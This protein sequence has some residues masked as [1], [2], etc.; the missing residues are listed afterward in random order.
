LDG[1][2][3]TIAGNGLQGFA[4]DGSLA[5]NASFNTPADVKVDAQGNVY[6]VDSLNSSIRKLTPLASL[7]TPAITAIGNA[8]SLLGGPVAPGE[9][10]L[11]TGTA[12]GPG[13][14]VMFDKYPAP[15]LTSSIAG[16]LVVVPYEV[17]SQTASQVTVTVNGVT[18]APFAVQIAPAAPGI[19]TLTGDGLGQAV[20]FGQDGFR[21]GVND[22]A[23]AGSPVAV[24]CTGEGVVSPAATTGVPIGPSPPSPVLQVSATV[25]GEPADVVGAYSLPGAMGQFIVSVVIPNDIATDS[26]ATLVIVVGNAA[27]QSTATIAVTA[28]PDQSISPANWRSVAK[29]IMR[30]FL[31]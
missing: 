13:G 5:A 26:N 30:E 16:A 14:S 22:S 12:L 3:H 23:P 6:I 24:L 28:A 25:D 17:S 1:T 9:R 7:P 27:S 8:G 10:V 2:L 31:D 29:G 11:I 21:N 15:V 20:A 18:S 4:G 19:F